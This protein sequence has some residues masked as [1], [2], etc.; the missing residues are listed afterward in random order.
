MLI[1][2]LI[3]INSQFSINFSISRNSNNSNEYWR[4][5]SIMWKLDKVKISIC[6]NWKMCKIGQSN[7]L[8][9]K[10]E[11]SEKLNKVKI[12]RW[13]KVKI[14]KC[15][16]GMV[17]KCEQCEVWSLFRVKIRKIK[18]VPVKIIDNVIT[19]SELAKKYICLNYLNRMG[20]I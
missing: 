1:P 3:P 18:I 4:S 7:K 9:V 13:N 5:S 6:K 2:G 20:R 10:I 8:T 12:R 14:S 11:K 16:N 15:K 19:Y 17:W